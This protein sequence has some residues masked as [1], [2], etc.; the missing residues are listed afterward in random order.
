[1]ARPWARV[2]GQKRRLVTLLRRRRRG[3][4]TYTDV[5]LFLSHFEF[6]WYFKVYFNIGW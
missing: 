3:K 6:S 5:G 4:Q 1:M 2:W